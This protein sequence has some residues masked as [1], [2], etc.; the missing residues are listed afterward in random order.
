[1][2]EQV[3]FHHGFEQFHAPRLPQGAEDCCAGAWG[4]EQMCHGTTSKY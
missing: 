4:L 3:K 2:K 1:M